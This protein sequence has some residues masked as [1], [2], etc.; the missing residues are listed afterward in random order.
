MGR[1]SDWMTTQIR[2]RT[3]IPHWPGKPNRVTPWG[4]KYEILGPLTGPNGGTAWIRTV[5]IVRHGESA[6]R[7][8]TLIPARE[9]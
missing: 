5:W 4:H 3:G 9:P 2:P 1:G 8:I 7:L 6:A